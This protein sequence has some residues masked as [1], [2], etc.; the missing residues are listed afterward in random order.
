MISGKYTFFFIALAS[1]HWHKM[2][3]DRI[4]AQFG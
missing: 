4:K 1:L 3:K 2:H